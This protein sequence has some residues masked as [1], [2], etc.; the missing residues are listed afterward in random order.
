MN[1]FF[2]TWSGY[3]HTFK[4]ILLRL[5]IFLAMMAL[6]RYTAAQV[7]TLSGGQGIIDLY[8]LPS[9][10][11]TA[12]ALSRFTGKARFFYQWGFFS[13]D[14]VYVL[15][16]CTF[17]RCAIRYFMQRCP[18][19]E[20][21]EE[22]LAFMPVVGGTADLFENTVLFFMLGSGS[23]PAAMCTL[24]CL[25]NTVKYLFVYASLI[26]VIVGAVYTFRHRCS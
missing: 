19:N 24:F 13:V 1:I 18:V 11:F 21:T 6:M 16:Y 22:K 3:K 12:A 5:V 7:K 26:T 15:S 23:A 17:Y 4:G 2:G 25:L 9:P 10:S 20:S 8:I 14:M